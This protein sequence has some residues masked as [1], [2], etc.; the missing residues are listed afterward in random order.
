MAMTT[1]PNPKSSPSS[2]H[3]RA[4][5]HSHSTFS[6]GEFSPEHLATMCMEHGVTHWSLT[7]HDTCE[8]A[9]HML[10]VFASSP[11]EYASLIFI[12]GIEISARDDRS[13][14][15]LGY[16]LDPHDPSLIDLFATRKQEREDR[17]LQMIELANTRGF[18]VSAQDVMAYAPDGV[19]ARPHLAHALVAG[20]YV[21]SMARA[22]DLYL[23]DGKPLYVES[24]YMSVEESIA[25]IRRYN[26]VAVVAHPGL[27][28]RDERIPA[29][30]DAGLDGI[31]CHHPSHSRELAA[32]YEGM[33]R[34]HNLLIT[35]SSDFHG[36]NVSAERR[37]GETM[38]ED[39]R[40][41]RLLGLIAERGG[42]IHRVPA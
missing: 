22:F 25:L 36:P 11:G 18:H 42:V 9:R 41:D 31:E 23:G 26:G 19:L 17:M 40:V 2:P 33:A 30:V 12:P 3:T 39:E 7:D 15:M 35:A 13:V 28:R 5:L 21:Q 6:D 8:G 1:T 4:E 14:H 29:W 20:G 34:R 10:D 27:S 37:F 16:G 38:L 32:H 24:P